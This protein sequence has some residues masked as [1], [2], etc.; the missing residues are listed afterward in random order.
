MKLMRLA[1]IGLIVFMV[2]DSVSCGK[3]K[4]LKSM[5]EN[6]SNITETAKAY[7]SLEEGDSAYDPA[8]FSLSE[9]EVRK[10]YGAVAKLMKKHPTVHFE[11]PY[12][13]AVEAM[14]AGI[15]LKETIESETQYDFGEFNETALA[16]FA[17]RTQG[18]GSEVASSIKDSKIELEEFDADSLEGLDEEQRAEIEASLEE[19]TADL[20]AFD[21]EINTDEMRKIREHYDM[22]MRVRSEFE[23]GD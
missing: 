19:Q 20:A 21:A 10:F 11:I 7:E 15:N 3:I 17:V 6:L 2:L 12:G 18:I 5:G 13:S 22:I 16:I 1:I 14:D 23:L 9:S 4:Q 8:N